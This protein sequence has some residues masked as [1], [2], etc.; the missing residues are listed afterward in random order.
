MDEQPSNEPT[1]NGNA[2]ENNRPSSTLGNVAFGLS[3][4]GPILFFSYSYLGQRGGLFGVGASVTS[5]I[6]GVV[7]RA[8]AKNSG[9]AR[10]AAGFATAA[11]V[12]S[13]LTLISVVVITALAILVLGSLLQSFFHG[14]QSIN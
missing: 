7:S 11:I 5:L 12:I 2:N 8:T 1:V 14:L 9:G 10:S 4:L 6:L 13:A 3:I